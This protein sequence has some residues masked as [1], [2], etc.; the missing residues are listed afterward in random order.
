MNDPRTH[1]QALA[2]AVAAA[3]VALGEIILASREDA[4]SKPSNVPQQ[5]PTPLPVVNETPVPAVEE[6]GRISSRQLGMLRKL[7]N[8]KLDGDW[9]AFDASCKQRFGRATAYLTTKEAS[10]LISDLLGGGNHGHQS[11]TAR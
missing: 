10:T 5:T 4:P 2:N 7:V 1:Y 8:E 6:K 11:R 9:N 3:I